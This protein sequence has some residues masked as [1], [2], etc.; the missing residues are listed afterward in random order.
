VLAIRFQPLDGVE[1]ELGA[2]QLRLLVQQGP[3]LMS[4]QTLWKSWKILNPIGVDDLAAGAQLLD[5]RDLEPVAACE[6]RGG[7]SRHAG[8][9]DHKIEVAHR[10]LRRR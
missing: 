10:S 3:E 4:A 2:G 6:H 9:H 5:D 1:H 7:Q 8:A